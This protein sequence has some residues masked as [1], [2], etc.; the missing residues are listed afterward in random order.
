MKV[1]ISNI[2]LN[3]RTGPN[4]FANRLCKELISK[5][6]SICS[7][8][9]NYDS[10]LAFIN[11][12]DKPRENS[13][14]VQRLDGIWLKPDDFLIKNKEIR[15][16]YDIAD[17]V[18]WQSQFNKD[19]TQFHW[20]TKD[21]T[22]IN[23]GIEILSVSVTNSELIEIRSK[24]DRLFVC[25]ANWRRHKR[26][27]ENIELFQAFEKK[28]S[29]LRCGL[30]IMGSSPDYFLPKPKDNIF[31]VGSLDHNLCLQVFAT[32]D[33]MFHLAY[34]D[35]CPN[36]VVESISQNCP[37]VCA[38]SGGTNEIVRSNGVVIP[39]MAPQNF[40]VH[41]YTKPPLIDVENDEILTSIENFITNKSTLDKSYLDIE[42]VVQKYIEVLGNI[43]NE[44]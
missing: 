23:N 14:L 4:S 20:G 41:D 7:S 37:V 26:L 16:T 38:S 27:K 31:Y 8:T 19:L 3:S 1:H 39:E 33:A 12:V 32:A 2:D 28:F 9:E 24:F 43:R 21:G 42:G 29:H 34:L 6:H 10:Y 40:S 11:I 35:H 17:H 15:Y 22:V 30:I 36:T 18:I 25:S 5:G 44:K 13:R